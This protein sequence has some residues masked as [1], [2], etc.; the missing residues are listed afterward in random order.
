ME[1]LTKNRII[2]FITLY[3]VF[4]TYNCLNAQ[5]THTFA[6]GDYYYL[7]LTDSINYQMKIGMYGEEKLTGIYQVQD[8]T[9][10]LQTY[11]FSGKYVSI[12][13]TVAIKEKF[14]KY[15]IRDSL[16]IPLCFYFKEFL[17][18]K[19]LKYK[20]P[21]YDTYIMS[22]KHVSF[23]FTLKPDSTFTYYTGSDRDGY[24]VNGRW[25]RNENI[26][27]LSPETQNYLEMLG[28]VCSDNEM[29]F[30]DEFLIG[31]VTGKGEY[32]YLIKN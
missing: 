15:L 8:D 19:I 13:D 11:N 23:R 9:V 16:L 12:I 6:L 27:L 18:L 29:L 4:Y 14:S 25:L 21:K 32:V 2:F 1:H 3:F 26:L 24:S 7:K 5:T 31:K 22:D 28:W 10:K 17:E 30:Y 20:Q